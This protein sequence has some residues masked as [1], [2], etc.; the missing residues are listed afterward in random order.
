MKYAVRYRKDFRHFDSVDEVIFPV[1]K[2]DESICT[3]PLSIVKDQRQKITLDIQTERPLEEFLPFII[4]LKEKHPNIL[5][6][7]EWPFDIEEV[8]LMKDNNIPF[9]ASL[10][11]CKSLDMVYVMKIAGVSEIY[12]VENLGFRLDEV[13][14]VLKDTNIQIRV[15]PNVTQC[16]MGTRQW[17][18]STR[19]FWIRPEDTRFYEKYVDT[20]ELFNED[21]KLSVV[22]EVYQQQVWSGDLSDI[23]LDAEDLKISNAAIPPYFGQGR[24]DCKQHCLFVGGCE[25][26][27]ANLRFAKTFEKTDVSL[28]YPKVK[29]EN[30]YESETD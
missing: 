20:F 15:I 17:L 5:V 16:T 24:V 1:R 21:D 12:V 18:S 4:Q 7:I 28:I 11:F 9:M 19:K 29:K 25:A 14:K 6:Q 3:V 30:K 22:Y 2:G 10:G 27:E 13:K 26:C 23:I 8:Q